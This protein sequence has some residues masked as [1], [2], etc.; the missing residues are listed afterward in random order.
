MIV[1]HAT[2]SRQLTND[3]SSA[4]N[5]IKTKPQRFF[6]CPSSSISPS[7][8]LKHAA[9]ATFKFTTSHWQRVYVAA[10]QCTI[11]RN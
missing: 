1:S 10:Y 8:A 4:L 3:F 2:P 7:L 11:F 6:I 5:F 9:K